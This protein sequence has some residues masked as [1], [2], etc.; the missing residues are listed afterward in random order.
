MNKTKL[1]LLIILLVIFSSIATAVIY[2]NNEVYQI[3]SL[4]MMVE[5]KN[6]IGI[7]LYE[8]E[9]LNFGIV[10][11]G[12]AS[13]LIFNITSSKDV[14]ILVLKKGNIAGF[15]TLSENN[16]LLRKNELK[17]IETSLRIPMNAEFGNY[18]GGLIIIL[19]NV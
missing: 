1:I 12:G 6:K 16:F 17:R 15:I 3:R 2:F 4:P 5:V 19:R 18:S 9:Q 11:R 14:N 13:T 8:G 10:P 7:G